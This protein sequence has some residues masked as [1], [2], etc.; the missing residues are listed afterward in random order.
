MNH[1][2]AAAARNTSTA[3]EG[4]NI[5]TEEELRRAMENVSENIEKLSDHESELT[6]KEMRRR[7]VLL[8]KKE[9]LQKIKEAKEKGDWNREMAHNMTYALL[10]AFGEKHPFLL[11]IMQSKLRMD[12]FH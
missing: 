11:H 6:K 10:T 8:L 5:V 4:E 7:D 3:V 12:L 2:P 9:T 1:A